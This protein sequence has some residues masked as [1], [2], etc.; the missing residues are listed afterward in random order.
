MLFKMLFI[1]YLY[2]IR[3]E[4]R[5]VEEI[6]V[7]VA[8]RWFVGLSLTD[9]VPHSSTFSQNRRRRFVGTLSTSGNIN[10]MSKRMS[11]LSCRI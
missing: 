11:I 6:Q 5:R 1:G 7:N 4:R 8:Y 3:S 9:P 10:T 2:G